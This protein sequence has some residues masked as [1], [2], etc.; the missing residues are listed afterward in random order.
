MDE[1][2]NRDYAA[3]LDR[4]RCGVVATLTLTLLAYSVDLVKYCLACLVQVVA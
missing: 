3:A 2:L 1:I 4:R